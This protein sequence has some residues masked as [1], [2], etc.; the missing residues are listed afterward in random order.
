LKTKQINTYIM[1]KIL[2]AIGLA[3][4]VTSS[5][6]QGL[7]NFVNSA[8]TVITLTSNGVNI[9]SAPAGNGSWRYELFRAAAGTTT[10]SGF[11]ATGMVATNTTAGRFIYGNAVAIPGTALGG[12]AAILIRGW[13]ASLGATWAEAITK[14]GVVDGYFGSSAVAPNF[15][16]GGDGGLGFIQPSPVFGGSSGIVAAGANNGFTLTFVPGVVPEPSSMVL[17]GL[18]AASLLLFRR[19]K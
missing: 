1:K 17:A 7:C 18:G 5:Q 14:Q 2:I 10:D 6:A 11:I 9:G 12:T 19:R 3:A 13:S 15:L 16:L 4:L 8:A